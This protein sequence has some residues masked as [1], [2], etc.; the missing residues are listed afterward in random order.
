MLNDLETTRR[1][2]I[3]GNLARMSDRAPLAKVSTAAR[4]LTSGSLLVAL[5]A[6]TGAASA[7]PASPPP[8]PSQPTEPPGDSVPRGG[9]GA[10][11]VPPKDAPPP[12]PG[13]PS[14]PRLIKYAPPSYPPDAQRAGIEGAV[15]LK[16]DID[17]TG[18]VT[19]AEV[20]TPGGNGFDE[21]ALAAAPNLEFEPAR[22]PDGTPVAAR[23]LY[24]YTFTLTPR[25]AEAAKAPP[26]DV[27][28]IVGTVLT[29]GT[30]EPLPG[31]SVTLVRPDG[32][33]ETAT[34]DQGGKFR[35]KNLPPGKYRVDLAA[36]G[37]QPF[38][39]D[40][41]VTEGEAIEVRYRVSLQE[42]PKGAPQAAIEVTV[43][44]S[45]PPREVTKR[46][47]ER[48]EIDRIP[49]TGGDALRSL[50]NLPGVARVGF[51]GLL[52]VRGSAPQDTLTFIDRVPVPLI[53]HFGG[54]A[55]VVPTEMLEKIDF[56][57][58][59]FSSEYGRAMGGIVDVGLRSPKQDGKY[60][61]VAQLD[62][63]DGRL[64]LEGPIPFTT[65]WTF[66]AAGRRSWIDSWLGPVL[67]ETGS[68]VTQAPVYYD[69][70]F[71]VEGRLT[72]NDRVRMSFYGSDDAFELILD[73]APEDEPALTGDFGFH[74]AFKRVQLSYEHRFSARDRLTWTAA[75]GQDNIDF[76]VG[77]LFFKIETNSLDLRLEYANKLASFMTLNMGADISGGVA[78][79]DVRAPGR[80]P[81]GHPNN[82]PFSTRPFLEQSFAGAYSR[83]AAYVEAEIVP[84]ARARIVPGV[85][86]DYAFDTGS[87]DVSPR[88]SGRYAIVNEFPKTTVK[89]GVGLYHQP[90]QFQQSIEPFGTPGLKSNRAVH[91]GLG[92]EQEITKQ[93]EVS[94]DG[95]YKHLDDLVDQSRFTGDYTNDTVGYAAG[96]EILLK[97]KPDER[98]FG[99]AAYTL[100]R[101]VRQDEPGDPEVLTAF[102]QTHV[103]TVLG[104][105]RLGRGWEVGARFRL[106]S[107]NPVTPFV[108]DPTQP[109]CNPNRLNAIFDAAANQYQPL[110]F[111][112]D[113][114]E[115]LPLFH[116]LDVR[117]DKTWQFK[118]W[119]LSFYLDIQN[120]YNHQNPEGISYNY[121]YTK[122]E[123]VTGLPFLP[124][125]GF[126][127][128]F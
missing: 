4:R 84:S 102:D 95:Y 71:M 109:G 58:G 97:Y 12:P 17:K 69:Y 25:P 108:C 39:A 64:L 19:K 6:L 125:I 86:L 56:Y 60:H 68:N 73:E 94:V 96:G 122:R 116:Q 80:N 121:N 28:T 36:A 11:I 35:F 111:G 105:V 113:Y 49:G 40:E 29:A 33:R 104:N 1:A 57:P 42:A 72:P 81:A 9:A 99:W 62:L 20:A 74:T 32:G 107:G 61:G 82:Q 91:V 110:A 24:R 88:V 52:I 51:G 98:F 63:I 78:T 55:S 83:P 44:G 79:V 76:D 119:K 106:V 66:M 85:R 117:M 16:L 101:S 93:L 23:I 47:L 15:E 100:S 31:V 48:R 127:G 115:R 53:Y 118:H 90:P 18:R 103:L 46:T 30:N 112:G 114:S 92:V 70:Q 43:R 87:V 77:P 3:S 7:Q 21:A 65:N 67:R 124:T 126:R 5:V 38:T 54:L 2:P 27:E 123:I 34:T 45:R 50:Q 89:G 22:R 10:V 59:N 26:A 41:E 75:F 8:Q 128:D 13:K 14:M 120:I 37:F